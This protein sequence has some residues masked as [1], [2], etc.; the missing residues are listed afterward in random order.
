MYNQIVIYLT[1]RKLLTSSIKNTLADLKHKTF[2]L[3]ARN[4]HPVAFMIH[5]NPFYIFISLLQ[6][7]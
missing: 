1:I 3:K 5:C 6:F 4:V 2:I 7:F